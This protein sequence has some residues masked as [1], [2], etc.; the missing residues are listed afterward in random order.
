MYAYIILFIGVPM[1]NLKPK[2]VVC[3]EISCLAV[4][5]GVENECPVAIVIIRNNCSLIKIV[6]V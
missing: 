5:M 2:K 1:R 3:L 6:N 4:P